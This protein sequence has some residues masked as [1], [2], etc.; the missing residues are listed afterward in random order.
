MNLIVGL[1][2]PGQDYVGT[3]HNVG[4]RCLQHLARKHGMNFSRRECRSRVATAKIGISPVL[5]ARPYTYMNLSG[6]AVACLMHKHRISLTDILIIYDDMDL[7]P[8]RIRLRPQGS[9]GGHNGVQSIITALGSQDFPRLRIG[10]GPPPGDPIR[11]VLSTFSPEVREAMARAV[12]H[13]AE[14]VE[15]LLRDGIEA[16]MNQFNNLSNTA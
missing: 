6:S 10:I 3:R 4:F 7:D 5:L 8:G 14:A 1:G 11:Y 15:C 9:A 16:A 13:S 2:N 12:R